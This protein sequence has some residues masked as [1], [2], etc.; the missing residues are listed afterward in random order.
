MA[1]FTQGGS[2][3]GGSSP[4]NFAYGAFHDE[5]TFGPYAANSEHSFSYQTTDMSQDVHIGGINNDQIVIDRTGKF[6]IAFSA[7]FHQIN[8]SA[9]VYIWLA[10]NGTAVPWTNSRIMIAANTPEVIAAWNFFVDATAGDY[11]ELRWS[12]TSSQTQVYAM[13][14][15]TGTKPNVPSMILTV[16]QV[17]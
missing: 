17:G 5:T 2:S 13:T 14:N 6:N 4:Q 16:N 10:K 15:L 1:R 7:Q 11:Y 3:N 9:Y 8:S 12:S